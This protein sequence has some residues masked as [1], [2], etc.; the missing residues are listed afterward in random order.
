MFTGS[1]KSLV[2]PRL[3]MQALLIL[4]VFLILEKFNAGILIDPANSQQ[5]ASAVVKLLKDEQL[6]Q[7]MGENGRNIIIENYSWRIAVKK[8]KNI[9]ENLVN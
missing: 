6:R 8:M 7:K 9:F 2:C 1:V 3:T 5:F 4:Q